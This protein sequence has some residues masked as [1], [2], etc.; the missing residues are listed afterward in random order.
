ME[1]SEDVTSEEDV[2][3]PNELVMSE[4]PSGDIYLTEERYDRN[5]VDCLLDI[6]EGL[7]ASET[8]IDVVT[9]ATIDSLSCWALTVPNPRYIP[10]VPKKKHARSA[11]DSA[12]TYHPMLST[13]TRSDSKFRRSFESDIRSSSHYR[14]CVEP[15][16]Y[17][18]MPN[19]AKY[20]LSKVSPQ[21]SSPS[22]NVRRMKCLDKYISPQQRVVQ[23][24]LQRALRKEQE[25]QQEIE[26]QK[27]ECERQKSLLQ[28][29]KTLTDSLY[30]HESSLRQNSPIETLVKPVTRNEILTNNYRDVERKVVLPK[31]HKPVE[32]PPVE[33]PLVGKQISDEFIE[34]FS[35]RINAL[36][37][38]MRK[39][40]K[41]FKRHP[42]D[43]VGSKSEPSRIM[44]QH[45]FDLRD[46]QKESIVDIKPI[47]SKHRWHEPISEDAI[48]QVYSSNVDHLE[49]GNVNTNRDV[50]PRKDAMFYKVGSKDSE[51]QSN[52]TNS[53]PS[54]S[55]FYDRETTPGSDKS[56]TVRHVQPRRTMSFDQ[57]MI[58]RAKLHRDY[59]LSSQAHSQHVKKV[60]GP[61][62]SVTGNVVKPTKVKPKEK[63]I[64]EARTSSLTIN[65]SAKS[66]ANSLTAVPLG[67]SRHKEPEREPSCSQELLPGVAGKRLQMS[68]VKP[69]LL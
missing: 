26:K 23:R 16:T 28:Q 12:I 32:L 44:S 66:T 65:S 68:V 3:T 58:Q 35:R 52:G 53:A 19:N 39:D 2:T 46:V 37:D 56:G 6:D 60:P 40:V 7:Q 48:A 69:R 43:M 18:Y 14:Q 29:E 15:T 34:K 61:R 50:S 57:N 67:K 45:T 36:D 4:I 27:E 25:L 21:D 30:F 51:R 20:R 63:T 10:H 42:E 13:G 1:G 24:E 22:M 41:V 54:S 64:S 9:Q 11:D 59:R 31:L 55:D 62:T 5:L 33:I 8:L 17:R 38:E 47:V 49:S